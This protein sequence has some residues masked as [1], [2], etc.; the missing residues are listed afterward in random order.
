LRSARKPNAPRNQNALAVNVARAPLQRVPLTGHCDLAVADFLDEVPTAMKASLPLLA[1]LSLLPIATRAQTVTQVWAVRP[2]LP[3]YAYPGHGND[4]P[5]AVVLDGGGNAIVSGAI[6]RGYLGPAGGGERKNIYTAKYAAA[7]GALLWDREVKGS[8]QDLGNGL[9]VDGNG[10]VVITGQLL[11]YT[12]DNF[13]NYYNIYTAK[14]AA[15]TGAII[16]AKNYRPSGLASASGKAVAVD[17]SGN[18]IVTG[19]AVGANHSDLYTVKY[20]SADGAVIWERIYNG[21][22]NGVD[23]G[24]ALAL[25]GNGDAIVTGESDG[26]GTGR[27]IYTAKYAAATGAVLWERRYNGP[28]NGGDGGRAIAVDLNGN[29]IVT[30]SAKDINSHSG[31]YTAK[32]ENTTGAVLWEKSYPVANSGGELPRA[33][34]IDGFGNV[35]VTGQL[36]AGSLNA[37][38]TVKYAAT[39]GTLVW[40]KRFQ[41]SGGS[42][43]FAA[44]VDGAGNVIIGVTSDNGGRQGCYTAKYAASDGIPL[45][46]KRFEGAYP[47]SLSALAVTADGGAVVTGSSA[48]V[49]AANYYH[50]DYV[51][52]RYAVLPEGDADGDGLR[53]SWETLWWGTTA[54]H[55][56]LDDFD[57]DGMPEL[58]EMAF[59][60]NPKKAETNQ[61]PKPTNENGYLTLTIYKEPGVT[62]QVQSAGS[63]DAPAFSSVA[64]TVLIDNATTLKVRDNFLIAANPARYVRVKVTAAP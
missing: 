35:Y 33:M 32:Y 47:S 15:A 27:D 59:A 57:R 9:A 45:W 8:G 11:F 46:E 60:L 50:E 40:N 49:T 30:G 58:L 36:D 12:D 19:V 61:V 25:D 28:A 53:D 55:S 17:A 31:F 39:D 29:I 23:A 54:G 56:A 21:P 48:S 10:N 3:P 2:Y 14:Y 1:A 20:A 7:D 4:A 64:T 52:I 24:T 34:A 22:A 44:A 5:T 43:G 63:P 62:Y 13:T 18:V 38:Y 51:T 16:W 26:I 37:M 6:D 41:D 42:V